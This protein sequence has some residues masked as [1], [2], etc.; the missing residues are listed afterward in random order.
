MNVHRI[1]PGRLEQIVASPLRTGALLP[2]LAPLSPLGKPQ[3]GEFGPLGRS[4]YITLDPALLL[5]AQKSAAGFTAQVRAD[6]SAPPSTLPETETALAL[7]AGFSQE[8]SPAHL[9]SQEHSPEHLQSQDTRPQ[10][11]FV[12]DASPQTNPQQARQMQMPLSETPARNEAAVPAEST[13]AWMTSPAISSDVS[14]EISRALPETPM[15]AD[16][17]SALSP[18]AASALE[19]FDAGS[20]SSIQHTK[21]EDVQVEISH[22]SVLLAATDRAFAEVPIAMPQEPSGIAIGGPYYG[23]EPNFRLRARKSGLAS[24]KHERDGEDDDESPEQRRRKKRHRVWQRLRE[25]R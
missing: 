5:L 13:S 9:A 19:P 23:L 25:M 1:E 2:T 6:D 10:G 7:P 18:K 17:A 22:E 15:S 4:D 16:P 24:A 14:P 11:N 21:T 8:N 12:Q 3:P 20:H